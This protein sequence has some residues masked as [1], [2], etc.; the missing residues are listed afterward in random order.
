MERE[1]H[2]V[3]VAA[4]ELIQFVACLPVVG[5]ASREAASSASLEIGLR[6]AERTRATTSIGGFWDVSHRPWPMPDWSADGRAVI[7]E[8]EPLI[9]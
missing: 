7:L 4:R 1:S 5:L 9:D 3:G 6:L 2:V 8:R